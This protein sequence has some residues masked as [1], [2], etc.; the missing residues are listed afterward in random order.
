[1]ALK[2]RK[3]SPPW[4]LSFGQKELGLENGVTNKRSLDEADSGGPN[5]ERACRSNDVS[6]P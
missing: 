6:D 2:W 3:S 4:L 5:G 1:M